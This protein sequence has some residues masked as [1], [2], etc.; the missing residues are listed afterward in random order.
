[1]SSKLNCTFLPHFN[2]CEIKMWL[3]TSKIRKH[4]LCYILT[5][6]AFS[7]FAVHK[8][9]CVLEATASQFCENL[10]NMLF[11]GL[12]FQKLRRAILESPFYFSLL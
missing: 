11:L 7:F 8:K 9:W 1:M 10:V 3:I 5:N 2:I 4:S 12:Q 6:K